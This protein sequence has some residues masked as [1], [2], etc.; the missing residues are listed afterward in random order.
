MSEMRRIP[1]N[2]MTEFI[3]IAGE[4]YPSLKLNTDD[5]RQRY[6]DKTAIL[7]ASPWISTWG[8][9]RN[10][11]LLGGMHCYDFT[12]SLFGK[13]YGA[14][15]LGMVAVDF[16]HKKEAV[17]REMVEFYLEHYRAQGYPFAILWP[18]RPDF[19]H[20]MG[21]GYGSRMHTHQVKPGSFPKGPTKEHVRYL[22]RSDVPKLLECY[23]RFTQKYNGLVDETAELWNFRLDMAPEVRI[24]VVDMG[25]RIDA[26]FTFVFESAH[27]N[28]SMVNN[29]RGEKLVCLTREALSELFTFFNS[30]A[31][32]IKDIIIRT[33]E[34]SFHFALNDIRDGSDNIVGRIYHQSSVTG[35]GLMYRV[36]DVR[37]LFAQLTDHNF[38]DVTCKLRLNVKDTFLPKNAGSV[39][40]VLE[41]GRIR[42]S[43]GGAPDT[44]VT[45]DIAELSSLLFG[46]VRFSALYKYRRAEISDEKYIGTLDRIFAIDHEPI[47]LTMF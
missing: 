3:R 34:P 5:E 10:N 31:D 32:Q 6:L 30:Q 43:S 39:D 23:N 46:A 28:N 35:V 40:L 1:Q 38:G 24:V 26:F 44:E 16:M 47:C 8:L 15:G 21:F 18:F 9:Y 13:K 29:M 19:Y 2:E 20:D 7:N 25:G 11:R 37:S 14:G 33:P 36:L 22:E 42:E 17:A 4:A 12:I 45:I 41:N 27:A